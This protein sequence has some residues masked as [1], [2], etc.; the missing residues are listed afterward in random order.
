[1][2]KKQK[3]SGGV[4]AMQALRGALESSFR[5]RQEVIEATLVA[6]LAREHVFMLGP[7]G[8]AKSALC[9]AI[10]AAFQGNYFEILLTK[11]L[12]PEEVFGALAISK[13][14]QDI[15]ERNTDRK[16]PWAHFGFGD[17]IW[18]SSSAILNSLLTLLNER[19]YHNG[20]QV[21]QC[22]LQTFVSASN[23][24]PT[25]EELAALYDRFAI[26]L[27]TDRL[28][29]DDN[30]IDMVSGSLASNLPRL[31]LEQLADAQAEAAALPV[32]RDVLRL[33]ASIRRDIASEGIYVSD[34]KYVQAVRLMRARAYLAGHSEVEAEDLE[35]L[36]HVLWNEPDQRKTVRRIVQKYSNPLGEKIGK[37]MD[38][39]L[40]VPGLLQAKQVEG[41]EAHKKVKAALDQLKKLG[42]PETNP[43][44]QQAIE[45]ASQINQSILRDHLGLA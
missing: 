28:Q 26:R 37:I 40:E 35:I 38:G 45:R 34:R 5:E 44:L 6:V 27:V 43:K 4:N 13:L 9:R 15:Y 42:D 19:I 12:P 14:K 32:S 30:F 17:E 29:D 8:T 1:M 25:A 36:E 33:L 21:M 22:P 2:A 10:C 16:L 3:T 7:P 20:T 39:V 23:E 41:V 11:T 31:T 18:K 24:L